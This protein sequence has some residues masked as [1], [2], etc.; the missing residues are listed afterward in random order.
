MHDQFS[1]TFYS[2]QA[3]Q[4]CRR[5]YKSYRG[6]LCERCLTMGLYTPGTEV[7]HKIPLTPDNLADPDVT[8]NFQ[9]LMLLCDSC[10]KAVHRELENI[11]RRWS[12]DA[13]GKIFSR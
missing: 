10:H 9:N 7:H 2:S 4:N 13:D 12:V 1:N 6:G 5:A 3:W 11:T 8:L